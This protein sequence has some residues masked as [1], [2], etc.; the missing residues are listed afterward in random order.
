MV[1]AAK[2]TQR[3][4][5]AGTKLR[6]FKHHVEPDD[7]V[8]NVGSRDVKQLLYVTRELDGLLHEM[9]VDTGCSVTMRRTQEFLGCGD[10]NRQHMEVETRTISGVN[11][12]GLYTE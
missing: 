6:E 11:G 4:M 10:L 7:N 5:E 8:T 12:T 9:L 3:N 1:K 2:R